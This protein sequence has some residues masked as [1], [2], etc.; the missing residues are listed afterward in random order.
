MGKGDKKT[1]RGKI[2]ISSFGKLRLKKKKLKSS[3][4]N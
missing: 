1:R 3:K 4:N 2:I